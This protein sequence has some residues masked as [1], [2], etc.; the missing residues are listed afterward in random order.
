MPIAGA[1]A[2]ILSTLKDAGIDGSATPK[3]LIS[4]QAPQNHA[5]ASSSRICQSMMNA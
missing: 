5:S 3:A 1:T 4:S 2:Q